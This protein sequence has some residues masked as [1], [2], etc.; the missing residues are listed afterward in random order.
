M[1]KGNGY[2]ASGDNVTETEVDVFFF[3]D[4]ADRKQTATLKVDGHCIRVPDPIKEF[5]EFLSTHDPILV[6]AA[7]LRYKMIRKFLDFWC[8]FIELKMDDP[9][10]YFQKL[11]EEL[12]ENF[13]RM[14]LEGTHCRV[15]I[16]PHL[17][18]Q[19]AAISLKLMAK[20]DR[21]LILVQRGRETSL[22]IR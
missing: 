1:T 12:G 14:S 20:R 8:Q 4:I 7:V 17:I 10:R 13:R 11:I 9:G 16:E 2:N 19:Q 6:N 22:K 15:W 18:G 3:H 21:K 5:S